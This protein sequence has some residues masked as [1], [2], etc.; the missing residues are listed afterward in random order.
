[1]ILGVCVAL[2]VLT[3]ERTREPDVC[4]VFAVTCKT[5]TVLGRAELVVI[6]VPVLD[7][8]CGHGKA[9]HGTI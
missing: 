8:S 7:M 1:V 3:S 2:Q 6:C 9:V 5:M 4:Y